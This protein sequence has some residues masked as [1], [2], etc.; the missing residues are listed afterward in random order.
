MNYQEQIHTYVQAH[1]NEIVNVLKELIFIPST[2]GES[3]PNAPFGQACHDVLSHIEELYAQNGFATVRDE[4]GGYLLS[5]YGEGERHLGLFAHADVVPAGEDWILTAPFAPLEKD[6]FLVGRGASDDKSAVVISLYCAKMLRELGIPLHSQLTMFT[7]INEE[8]GMQDIKMYVA[9]HRAPDFSLVCDSAFPLYHGNKGILRFVATQNEPMQDLTAF[10]GGAAMNIIL[11]EVHAEIGTEC[12]VKRGISRHGALPEGSLNAAH[13][14]AKHLADSPLLCEKDKTQMAFIRDTLAGYYGE[15][16]GI[17]HTDVEFGKLTISNGM[18]WMEEQKISLS[19]DMR[20]GASVE[21]AATKEHI[22]NYFGRSGWD[23]DIICEEL[24]FVVSK[25]NPY[26]RACLDIYKDFTGQ[27]DATPRINAGGTYART[28]P[29]A[30]EIGT[31][32][33]GERPPFSLPSGHGGVHQPDEYISIDGLLRALEIT[34]LMLVACDSV[35][36][37]SKQKT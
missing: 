18:A 11:G 32:L 5:F 15:I 16:M 29:C 30:V 9:K 8:S 1:R 3:Q 37:R 33:F 20:F 14:M 12:F 34:A 22:R 24:P 7:G 25:E 28:L 13:V 36:H 2:R 17:A 27:T 6:G 35:A 10:Y 31:S 23:I 21:L 19:F 4:D 26:L